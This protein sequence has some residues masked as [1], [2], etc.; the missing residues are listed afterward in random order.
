MSSDPPPVGQST[1]PDTRNH[2]PPY[3]RT[4]YDVRVYISGSHTFGRQKGLS[5][6]TPRSNVLCSMRN[7]CQMNA[8]YHQ[9]QSIW[10]LDQWGRISWGL[11]PSLSAFADVCLLLFGAVKYTLSLREPLSSRSFTDPTDQ[12]P[13]VY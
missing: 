9:G 2:P 5:L 11:V 6:K 1:K 7:H 13:V 10:K 3:S 4:K 12:K 8:G